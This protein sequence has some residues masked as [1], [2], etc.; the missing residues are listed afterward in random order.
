[1]KGSRACSTA[2]QVAAPYKICFFVQGFD[3]W[4][5]RKSADPEAARSGEKWREAARN[6][7]KRQETARRSMCFLPKNQSFELIE[8]PTIYRCANTHKANIQTGVLVVIL[9]VVQAHLTEFLP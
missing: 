2:N 6:G 5:T 3:G 8:S 7:K 9:R 4:H 1:L